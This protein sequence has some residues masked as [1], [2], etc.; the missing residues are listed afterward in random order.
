MAA[1]YGIANWTAA[2]VSSLTI[3]TFPAMTTLNGGINAAQTNITLAAWPWLFPLVGNFT[4]TIGT[5]KMT[6]TAGHGT[7]NLTVTRAAL[8]TT[9][10]SHLTGVNVDWFQPFPA[11]RV[12]EGSVVTDASTAD[13]R[14][15]IQ[16]IRQDGPAIK[17]DAPETEKN[18]NWHVS[19]YTLD[20]WI[21]HGLA[22]N[23][24]QSLNDVTSLCELLLSLWYTQ[25]TFPAG[26]PSQITQFL[27][28]KPI[29]DYAQDPAFATIPITIHT[30]M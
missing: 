21:Y 30:G 22:Q 29:Y 8:G 16:R 10:A 1:L 15:F 18:A 26:S 11:A 13:G 14:T 27:K 28:S 19:K 5:E 25:T 12:L 17:F 6:V 2:L 20:L 24:T 4:I 3:L 7:V 23:A 9:A